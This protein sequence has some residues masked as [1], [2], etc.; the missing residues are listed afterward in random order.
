MPNLSAIN[1]AKVVFS[2][3]A[4]IYGI[5]AATWAFCDAYRAQ[6]NHKKYLVGYAISVVFFVVA[7]FGLVMLFW[8]AA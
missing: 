4:I 8:G 5:A 1:L 7:G 3:G 6:R 2:L